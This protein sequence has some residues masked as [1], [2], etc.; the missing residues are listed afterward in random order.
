MHRNEIQNYAD[1]C[2]MALV[3]KGFQFFR[4]S[5][6][7][8]WA[9]ISGVLIAPGFI[10]GIL[11]KRHDFYIVVAVFFQI[12]DE[13]WGKLFVGVPVFLSFSPFFP[14]AEM[15]LVDV[16]WLVMAYLAAFLPFGIF[17]FVAAKGIGFGCGA[18]A[19]FAVECVGVC[20]VYEGSVLA[21]D[22][23]F[24]HQVGAH[25]V[26]GA[27]PE[28]S[29]VDAVHWGFSPAVEFSDYGDALCCRGKGAEGGA[30]FQDVCAKVLIGFKFFAGVKVVK[31]HKYP[32]P[33]LL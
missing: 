26:N 5:V 20:M 2:L 30:A 16:D 6:A 3:Y 10:A 19:H 29:I 7:G 28:I 32:L 18:G 25:T 23:V 11:A 12:G 9:E 22:S 13:D 31:I 8:S 27:F 15:H 4:L 14:G 33:F 21:V 24:V 1:A 17:E